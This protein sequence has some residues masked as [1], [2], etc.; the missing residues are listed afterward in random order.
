MWTILWLIFTTGAGYFINATWFAE[1]NVVFGSIIGFS[2]GAL[3]R[4][5]KAGMSGESFGDCFDSVGD[6]GGGGS[7]GGSSGG[8]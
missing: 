3:L 8:D 2:V 7:D 5:L 6:F 4:L 1:T